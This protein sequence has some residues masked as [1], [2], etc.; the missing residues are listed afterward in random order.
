M[1]AEPLLLLLLVPVSVNV[2]LVKHHV[3]HHPLVTGLN[4]RGEPDH[5]MLGEG[6]LLRGAEEA[7]PV[8]SV[9]VARQEEVVREQVPS[10]KKCFLAQ[11]FPNNFFCFPHLYSRLHFYPLCLLLLEVH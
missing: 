3:V 4:H 2:T 7:A 11:Y 5:V 6:G 9:V 8:V 10:L 1:R